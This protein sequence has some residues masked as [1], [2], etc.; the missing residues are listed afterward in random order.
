MTIRRLAR[1]VRALR[2]ERELSQEETARRAH[3]DPKHIQAIEA[4]QTNAT[5]ASLAG[6][7]RAFDVTLAVLFDG[8]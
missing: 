3:L 2:E 4:G 6:L 7:S 1:R 8:V 5:V